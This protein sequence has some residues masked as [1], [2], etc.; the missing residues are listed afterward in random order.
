[1]TV[2]IINCLVAEVAD[3]LE[4]QASLHWKVIRKIFFHIIFFSNGSYGPYGAHDLFFSSA[5]PFYT[6]GKP[7]WT[8]ETYCKAATYTQGKTN[9]E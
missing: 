7:P 2:Y 5:V 1:M 3:G 4:I 8:S 6:D 9:T